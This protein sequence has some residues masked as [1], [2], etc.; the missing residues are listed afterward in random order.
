MKEEEIRGAFVRVERQGDSVK[1]LV[2]DITWE[3]AHSPT[4]N[5][6]TAAELPGDDKQVESAIRRILADRRYF[7]VCS[8]CHER[9]PV[10][11]LSEWEEG[12]VVCH[13]CL[14][15]NHGVAF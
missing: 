7:Q 14:E 13:G 3:G 15:R 11:W 4:T 2:A 1:I 9:N 5:W 12:N 8:E 10:G 6:I